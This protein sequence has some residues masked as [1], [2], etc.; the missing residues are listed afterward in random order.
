MTRFP[1]RFAARTSVLLGH[2]R[3]TLCLGAL[4]LAALPAAVAQ[5]PTVATPQAAGSAWPNKPVRFVVP[6][7]A[8]TATDVIARTIGQKLGDK[9]GQ[10]VVIDNRP[11]AG[12]NLGTD[13]AAKS[14]N[15][16]YTLLWG[17]VANAISPSLY[18]K[19]SYNFT[20]DFTPIMLVAKLPLVLVA[21]KAVPANNL[22]QLTSYAKS[23]GNKLSFGSG[24]VGT[25]NH[26]AGEMFSTSTGA[27][28]VHVPYKGTPSAYSDLMAGRVDMMFDNIVPAMAQIKSG[29]LKP[30]AVSSARRSAALPDVPTVS[31]SGIPGFEAVSWVG[32]LAPAGTPKPILDKIHQDLLAVLALPD[33]KE[34]MATTGA[35]LS[36]G[37]PADF[38][39]FIRS[40]T[41]KWAKA[42][43]DSGAHAE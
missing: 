15:D 29:Q 4:A 1:S 22:A 14:P 8:A 21:N 37:T 24:G 31:E 27:G 10:P 28:L 9:W 42:V 39:V 40:E 33:V 32:L 35:E 25:S 3:R 7:P 6:F 34:R 17:T 5:T 18:S 16:G 11:G 20:K 30:I 19:L 43:K 26:L 38:E 36:P 41:T 12:G 2:S 13:I 23:S